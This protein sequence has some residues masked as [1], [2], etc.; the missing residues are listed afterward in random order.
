MPRAAPRC[1]ETTLVALGAA[2]LFRQDLVA[3]SRRFFCADRSTEGVSRTM[4]R[5]PPAK[6]TAAEKEEGWFRPQPCPESQA[7]HG[8]RRPTDKQRGRG[9]PACTSRRANRQLHGQQI[10]Q[11]TGAFRGPHAR[12]G[13]LTPTLDLAGC[14]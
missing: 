1:R 5:A 3:G 6:S 4:L 11:R 12:A 13:A 8:F 7:F 14:S 10:R 9:R 2:F